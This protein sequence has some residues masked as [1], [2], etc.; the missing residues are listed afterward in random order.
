MNKI[1]RI[2]ELVKLLNSASDIYYNTSDTVMTDFEFDS[3]LKD[4]DE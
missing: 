2:K 4:N 1:D 3:L